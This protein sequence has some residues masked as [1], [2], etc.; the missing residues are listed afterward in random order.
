[1]VGRRRSTGRVFPLLPRP[2]TRCR[3]PVWAGYDGAGPR[4]RAFRDTR[5]ADPCHAGVRPDPGVL[6]AD[7]GAWTLRCELPADRGLH[8]V[9][10]GY[11]DLEIGADWF[12][13]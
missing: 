8:V 4:A 9:D 2:D 13:V 7:A 11:C 12:P 3:K 6:R 10:R 5:A 1:M